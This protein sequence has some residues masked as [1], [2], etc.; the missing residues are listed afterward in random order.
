MF[1]FLYERLY[2][3]E[4]DKL[5]ELVRY[6]EAQASLMFELTARNE[7]LESEVR[8]YKSKYEVMCLYVNDDEAL[9]E[10]F[11]GADKWDN[12]KKQ[13]VAKQQAEAI[14]GA[15]RPCHERIYTQGGYDVFGRRSPTNQAIPH[16]HGLRGMQSTS[17]FACDFQMA[18]MQ[19]KSL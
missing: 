10:L 18:V 16:H 8:K 9:L 12:Y 15:Q 5:D 11:D 1:N 2:R 6:N 17:P 3:D 19:R 4:I 14:E 7:N 13:Q